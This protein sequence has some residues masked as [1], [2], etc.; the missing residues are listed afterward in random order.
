MEHE[1]HYRIHQRPA[2]VPILSQIVPIDTSPF[3]F[4]KNQ[5]RNGAARLLLA[6][7]LLRVICYVRHIVTMT[8]LIYWFTYVLFTY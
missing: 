8:L 5:Q 6:M 1:V 2:P 4:M 3:H 7:P